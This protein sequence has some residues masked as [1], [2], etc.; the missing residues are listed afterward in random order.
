MFY[1]ETYI[2]PS[3]YFNPEENVLP[4]EQWESPELA[5]RQGNFWM[6]G[7]KVVAAMLEA[8]D[9]G[10]DPV[11]IRDKCFK[12]TKSAVSVEIIGIKQDTKEDCTQLF[13][14]VNP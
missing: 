8:K 11:A 1:Y 2:K 3:F 10:S 7:S 4:L 5:L 13:E 14:I 9:T 6:S 12:V